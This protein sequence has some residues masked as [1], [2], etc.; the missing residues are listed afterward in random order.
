M[1]T[2]S[3]ILARTAASLTTTTVLYT[4]PASTTTVVTNI[5]VTNTTSSSGTFT[6][7]MGP[8]GSQVALHTGTLIS[9][10]STVYIDLKQVLDT[11]NTITG[12]ASAT[13]I[14]FHINGVEI[15]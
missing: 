5:A 2:T 15:V 4:V 11:T 7:A 8:S 14:N 3:K 12:G 9:A 1:A 10:N 13:T 6:L